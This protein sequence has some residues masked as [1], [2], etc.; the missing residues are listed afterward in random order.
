MLTEK[1]PPSWAD[2]LTEKPPPS[3]AFML[4]EKPPPS[5]ADMLIGKPPPSWADMLTEKPPPSWADMLTEKPPPCCADMLTGEPPPGRSGL[6][7][8]VLYKVTVCVILSESLCKYCTVQFK[9]VTI[10]V[11]SHQ[12]IELDI[13]VFVVLFIY[14]SIFI[15]GLYS[16][17]TC[18]LPAYKKHLRNRQR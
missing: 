18:A 11:L 15:C 3:W 1:L 17:V 5:W 13:H 2:M 9:T 6:N 16:K 7:F 8:L 10:K 4:T 12:V 14:P